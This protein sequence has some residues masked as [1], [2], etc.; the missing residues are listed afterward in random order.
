MS[1]PVVTKGRIWVGQF[2]GKAGH[3]GWLM[4]LSLNPNGGESLSTEQKEAL[5]GNSRKYATGMVFYRAEVTLKPVLNKNGKYIVRL[6]KKKKQS[7]T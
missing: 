5:S 3:L 4:P 6:P 7:R 1:E 2:I